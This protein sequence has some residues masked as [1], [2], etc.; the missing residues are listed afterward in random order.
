MRA[1]YLLNTCFKALAV[2]TNSDTEPTAARR[3]HVRP[4]MPPSVAGDHSLAPASSATRTAPP[5]A[6]VLSLS[7]MYQ[8]WGPKP[9]RTFRSLGAGLRNQI[10]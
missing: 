4:P 5:Q 1:A 6:R 3:S 2:L 10:F 9:S 8:W 7:L